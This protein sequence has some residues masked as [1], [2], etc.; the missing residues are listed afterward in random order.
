LLLEPSLER[1]QSLLVSKAFFSGRN[2]NEPKE[3][4]MRTALKVQNLKVLSGKI[5]QGHK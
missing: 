3:A 4:D 5:W 2:W 1:F